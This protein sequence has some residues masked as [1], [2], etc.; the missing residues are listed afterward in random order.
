MRCALR[1]IGYQL[2]CCF[3]QK[4]ACACIV[5]VAVQLNKIVRHFCCYPSFPTIT[6]YGNSKQCILQVLNE[7]MQNWL[8]LA[9]I[10]R[11]FQNKSSKTNKINIIMMDFLDPK[12]HRR[13]TAKLFT[14]YILSG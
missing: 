11:K 7:S 9:K 2:L 14:A 12:Q 10:Q 1:C 5:P 6:T 3:T 13:Q 4:S 8:P